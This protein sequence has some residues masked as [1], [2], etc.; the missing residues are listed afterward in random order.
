MASIPGMAKVLG[1]I[2]NALGKSNDAI[3]Q[4]L[5]VKVSFTGPLDGSNNLKMDVSPE[6]DL[7]KGAGGNILDGVEKGIGGALG[8]LF[9][10]K[11]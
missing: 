9:G 7:P 4:A 2:N 5:Q 1:S 10:K 6:I 3:Q 11:K 8:D